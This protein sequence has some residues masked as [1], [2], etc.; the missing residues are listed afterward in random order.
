MLVL[1]KSVAHDEAADD[2]RRAQDDRDDGDEDQ[3]ERAGRGRRAGVVVVVVGWQIIER[4][5]R[6]GRGSDADRRRVGEGRAGAKVPQVRRHRPRRDRR[7]EGL[8]DGR[9]ARFGLLVEPPPPP[10][11][12]RRDH[13]EVENEEIPRRRDVC[14]A[15]DVDRAC[16]D[17]AR[18]RQRGVDGALERQTLGGL[19]SCGIDKRR[20]LELH[21]RRS[22]GERHLW[23]RR[24]RRRRGGRR[25]G[26]RR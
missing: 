21:A 26:R 4:G 23:R 20:T 16:V 19:E 14:C 9:I 17:A 10:I 22:S 15:R 25:R 1:R 18:R 3:E 13:R 2:D 7:D 6:C 12:M 5:R 24:Q 11:A 8:D